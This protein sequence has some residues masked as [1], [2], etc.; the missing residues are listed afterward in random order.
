MSSRRV[1]GK[2]YPSGFFALGA[3]DE[4]PYFVK[5]RRGVFDEIVVAVPKLLHDQGIIQ[6]IAPL[7]TR[8]GQLW[9]RLDNFNLTLY[10]F[11]EG[12]DGFE[13]GLADRHWV[14]FGRAL[15]G[16][17]TRIVPAALLSRLPRENYSVQWRENVKQFQARVEQDP[18]NDPVSAALAA[19]LKAKQSEIS[20]LVGRSERLAMVL[21]TQS[22]EIVLCHT[23]IHAGNILIS[24]SNTLYI[25]DWGLGVKWQTPS[26][27]FQ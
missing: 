21:Q 14:D 25:V 16:I 4:T 19:F 8:S 12:H 3:D 1:W 26:S 5:L 7:V 10:P 27:P 24:V 9:T 2:C 20:D 18:L 15:K 13:V 23:D 6:I 22:L 17:H 11:V